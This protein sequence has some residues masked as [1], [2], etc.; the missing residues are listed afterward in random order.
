MDD[1]QQSESLVLPDITEG[2]R[3]TTAEHDTAEANNGDQTNNSTNQQ[4]ARFTAHT[5]QGNVIT[6]PVSL[7]VGSLIA[8]TTFNVITPDQLHPHFKP[9]LC[10]VDNFISGNN[11]V[12]DLKATHIVIHQAE[13]SVGDNATSVSHLA[14]TDS[15]TDAINMPV[16]SV[17][18]KNTNAELHKSRFGSGGRGRCIKLNDEWYTPSEFEAYCGRAS[19][20]D[21][22]R[23][24]RFGGLGLQKLIDEQVLMP[25]ATSCTCAACCDDETATGPIRLFTPYK[26]R[27]RQLQELENDLRI[28]VRREGSAD[29]SELD[30]ISSVVSVTAKDEAWQSLAEG[31]DSSGGAEYQMITPDGQ[32]VTTNLTN[33]NA[34]TDMQKLKDLSNQM[35][36]MNHDFRRCFAEARDIIRRYMERMQQE[37][38]HTMT[39][40]ATHDEDTVR[41]SADVCNQLQPSNIESNI[42]KCANCN[43]EALAECSLCRRTPYC[44]TFCQRKDWGSHQVECVRAVNAIQQQHEQQQQQSHEANVHDTSAQQSGAQSIM[45]IVES[46]Q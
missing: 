17:R 24:I 8:G 3:I 21:W 41:V 42:K 27:R 23:S 20:K 29:E 7:P 1:A 39:R 16:L 26:R 46:D 43:R 12:D 44:S 13:G 11:T 33:T 25:H 6:V 35:I 5:D 2:D 45:L 34:L 32:T 37:K 4:N 30:Q 18:C 22:K 9:M 31:I 38:E 14:S 10:S 36:K 19:S 28:K 40:L 15:W